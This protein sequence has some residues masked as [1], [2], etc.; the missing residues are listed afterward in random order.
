MYKQNLSFLKWISNSP[1]IAAKE[2]LKF[3]N[4][5]MLIKHKSL[6][7][8]FFEFLRFANSVPIKVT[9]LYI[10]YLMAWGVLF[11]IWRA[12]LFAENF[13]KNFNLV[14]LGISLYLLSLLE[15]IW[16]CIVFLQ[17]PSWL[18]GSRILSRSS[19]IKGFSAW[20]YFNGGS[21]E[22]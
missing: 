17:L 11:C 18:R 1:V 22:L 6:S 10:I 15:I 20:L 21:E 4:L 5:L 12:K 19:F 16:S 13:S 7:L 2:F 14:Y 3:L 8:G 9:L